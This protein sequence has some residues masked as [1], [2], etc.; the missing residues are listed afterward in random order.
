MRLQ[1]INCIAVDPI[2]QKWFGTTKG[3]FLMSSDGSHLIANYNSTNSPL[4]TDNIKS[5][6]VSEN[7]GIIYIGTDFGLTEIH[8]LFVKP[9]SNFSQLYAYPNPISISKNVN[10]NII[11]DGLVENSEIKILDISG[12]LINEFISIGGKTTTWNL[13]NLDN[14]LVASGVYIIVAF[15]SEANQVAQ[16][17]IA[18]LRK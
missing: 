4:P 16:T 15:D 1:T 3:V 8:T 6:A 5:I 13:K 17:K 12:N 2:N 11:I 10:S 14:Q 9:N 7:K 18:V